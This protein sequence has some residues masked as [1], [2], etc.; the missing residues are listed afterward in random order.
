MIKIIT[1]GKIKSKELNSMINYYSKQIPRK[2]EFIEI[3]D[4]P[5][6]QGINKEGESI[7]K[8]IKHDDFVIT[9][10]INGKSLS[11]EQFSEQIN[12]WELS[13]ND[14]IF[15]IGGSYGI[16]EKVKNRSNYQLS[17]SQMTFPHQLM[18]LILIEQI[19]RAY[20]IMNNH[21]YHK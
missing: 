18:K 5:N 6:I 7:L 15:I 17:F 9:L 16:S 8:K 10:E 13:N 4:E 19:Y 3:K 2:I 12:L 11:S 14:I 21:P 20:A 1:V